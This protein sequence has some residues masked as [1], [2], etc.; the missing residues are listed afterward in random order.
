MGPTEGDIPVNDS[1]DEF[2]LDDVVGG[3]L[4]DVS[5]FEADYAQRLRTIV[6]PNGLAAKLTTDYRGE[7]IAS[8]VL[9]AMAYYAHFVKLTSM[10]PP[11]DVM[12]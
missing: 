3:L 7:P 5:R 8:R 12:P 6:S 9:A 2:N 1:F 10:Y 4:S 11:A